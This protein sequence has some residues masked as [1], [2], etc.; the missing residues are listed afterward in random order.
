MQFRVVSSAYASNWHK[1]YLHVRINADSSVA[2]QVRFFYH[3]YLRA[4]HPL[5]LCWM[6]SYLLDPYLTTKE[7]LPPSQNK[8]ISNA[9]LSQTTLSL[10]N[11]TKKSTNIY[12]TKLVLLDLSKIPFY[13]PHHTTLSA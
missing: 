1:L 4:I 11:L 2:M 13:Y 3:F 8:S 6:F 9:V 10:A 12:D 5:H 7:V